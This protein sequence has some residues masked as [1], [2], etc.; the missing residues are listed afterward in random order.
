MSSRIEVAHSEPTDPRI[1]VGAAKV[2]S[3]MPSQDDVR[4]AFGKDVFKPDPNN[5]GKIIA[6][7]DR[8]KDRHAIA[9]WKEMSAP[10][11]RAA[12]ERGFTTNEATPRVAMKTQQGDQRMIRE[13][14]EDIMAE[15]QGMRRAGKVLPSNFDLQAERRKRLYYESLKLKPVGLWLPAVSANGGAEFRWATIEVIRQALE[16]DHEH[17][18]AVLREVPKLA[19]RGFRQRRV[20]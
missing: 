6:S 11:R 4:A 15:R 14:L 8:R 5:P 12:V 10:W 13:D 9:K 17:D 1:L 3:L 19:R 16:I 20:A 7:I 18:E 2:R